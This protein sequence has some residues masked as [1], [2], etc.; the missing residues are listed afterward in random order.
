M[1][2][3]AKKIFLI[4]SAVVIAA[5]I[6]YQGVYTRVYNQSNTKDNTEIGTG[7]SQ[8]TAEGLVNDLTG[9]PNRYSGTK[10]N[11]SAVQYI[12]NSFRE[13]GLK[14]FYEGSYYQSFYGEYLK[15]SWYYELPVHGTVENVVGRIPGLDSSKAVVITAHMDSFH[16]KGVLDNASGTAVLLRS[17]LL[18][19]Q[20]FPPGE[21][22]VD[23]IFVA[24]NAEESYLL[25]SKAFYKDLSQ[26]YA[27][28]YNINMDCVGAADK[29]L[30]IKNENEASDELY[31]DFIPFLDKHAIPTRDIAYAVNEN[32][33]ITG[34]SD[35]EV[36]QENGRAAIILGED[37]I[38]HL[39]H[40][41]QD[42]D[43]KLLDFAELDRLTDA[44][45]DF[46]TAA[47]GKIY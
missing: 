10:S 27:D 7:V 8:K 4:L 42:N 5:F 31:R 37:N 47:D 36:F 40:T 23:I 15:N 11:F 18:L 32:G 19:S 24:F 2:R 38:V 44:V 39:V 1:K 21:Y 25:G 41:R 14:P 45:V 6:Y 35:H 34:T 33:Y 29:P 46:V 22:P 17:A 28:F 12:R 43:R 3:T 16:S 26:R 13:A 20:A 9:F 30:A